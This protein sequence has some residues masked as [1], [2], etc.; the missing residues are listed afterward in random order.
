MGA[1]DS[2][3]EL[4]LPHCNFGH[5]PK[6]KQGIKLFKT[7]PNYTSLTSC[8]T[9]NGPQKMQQN[10]HN[11]WVNF[12]QKFLFPGHISQFYKKSKFRS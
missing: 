9:P 6:F 4:H 7:K 8:S 5:I 1:K 12:Q 2:G 11:F 10:A 3:N